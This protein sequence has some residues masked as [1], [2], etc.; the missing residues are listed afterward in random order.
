MLFQRAVGSV[1]SFSKKFHIYIFQL[2]A[3][4]I[5]F[6]IELFQQEVIYIFNDRSK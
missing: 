5:C 1:H 6:S 4:L 2:R 3:I